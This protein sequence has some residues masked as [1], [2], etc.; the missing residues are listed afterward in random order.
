M[1][2]TKTEGPAGPDQGRYVLFEQA[3]LTG[4]WILQ[5]A[6]T[7]ALYS[8][9]KSLPRENGLPCLSSFDAKQ[10]GALMQFAVGHLVQSRDPLSFEVVYVGEE[11]ARMLGMSRERRILSDG[12][13]SLNSADVYKRLSDAAAYLQ[14]HFVV[15]TLGWQG[16]ELTKYEVLI[17]PFGKEGV[18]GAAATLSVMSFSSGFDSKYWLN[19][20]I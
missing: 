10:H 9:W 15:K 12:S 16:R 19:G 7:K 6:A 14:P 20:G 2:S 13:E 11:C 18:V 1:F 4:D 8:D 3:P 17:L 5:G